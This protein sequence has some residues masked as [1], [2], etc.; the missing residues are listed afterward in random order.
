MWYLY[1]FRTYRLIINILLYILQWHLWAPKLKTHFKTHS[2][3]A[4]SPIPDHVKY[5]LCLRNI[6]LC[7]DKDSMGPLYC[8]CAF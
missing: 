1:S 6:F 7:H 3:S 8:K 5:N 4:L 2:P